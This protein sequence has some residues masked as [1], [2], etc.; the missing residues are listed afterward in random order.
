MLIGGWLAFATLMGGDGSI[1][2]PHPMSI[3]KLEMELKESQLDLHLRVQILTLEEVPSLNLD[4]DGDGA[5]SDQELRAAWGDIRAYLQAG[6]LISGNEEAWVPEFSEFSRVQE[7]WDWLLCSSTT[8]FEQ[9]PSILQVQ[10]GLFFQDG[11]PDHRMQVEVRGLRTI[12]LRALLSA[13]YADHIFDSPQ[14]FSE[15]LKFGFVHVLEG[16]D[17]LAFLAA[18][19]FGVGTFLGLLTTV[20]AFTL[21]HTMTLGLSAIGVWSLAPA[22]VEPGIALSIVATLWLH[23]G[24]GSQSSRA[25]RPAFGFG[26]LH[27]FGFAGLLGE[28]GLPEHAQW[29]SL[30]SFNLGVELAQLVAVL[31]LAGLGWFVSRKLPDKAEGLARLAALGLGTFGLMTWSNLVSTYALP[32][33]HTAGWDGHL[34]LA[35]LAALPAIGAAVIAHKK[36]SPKLRGEI[37][38]C[39][40]L[41]ALY[42][43]GRVTAGG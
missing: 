5:T 18:L 16:L 37:L 38:T 10:T 12:P 43:T 4:A 19:L 34:T 8:S 30:C 13:E 36:H 22:W 29:V 2:D 24:Q 15:Y 9:T 3:S 1:A 7:D 6:L 20:T 39:L 41:Y 25:W 33:I 21:A 31:P 14:P 42:L 40:F 17:H 11:N 23:R 35:G 26:L 27:G 32:G 28:I